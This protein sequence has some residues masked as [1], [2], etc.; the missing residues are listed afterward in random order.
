MYGHTVDYVSQ[1][2]LSERRKPD[3]AATAGTLSEST[4]ELKEKPSVIG[5][6]FWVALALVAVINLVLTFPGFS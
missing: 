5:V 6:V 1:D 4:P 3:A 2:Q